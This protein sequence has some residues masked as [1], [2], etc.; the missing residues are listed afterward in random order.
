[1]FSQSLAAFATHRSLCV[2]GLRCASKMGDNIYQ[3]SALDI[4][5]KETSMEKY[6][7]KVVL[8]VNVASK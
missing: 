4:D 5:G 8:I 2:I 1:V 7:G 3:F 6:R